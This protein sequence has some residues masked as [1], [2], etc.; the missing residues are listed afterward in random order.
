[1]AMKAGQMMNGIVV[2]LVSAAAFAGS[3]FAF[4][5][6]DYL[7]EEGWE[8]G[9]LVFDEQVE[10][11]E[12]ASV[13]LNGRDSLVLMPETVAE[14]SWDEE[15]GH[16][17]VDLESGGVIFAAT[18]GDMTVSVNTDFARVD[19]QN[20]TAYVELSDGQ[21]N[22]YATEH[23]SLVTFV[24]DGEDL[25]SISVPTEYWMKVP[26]SKISETV[27]KLRL[28]KL[29]KEFPTY[30][31][32][33]EDLSDEVESALDD[34]G[35]AYTESATKFQSAIKRAGEYGPPLTGFAGEA[36]E[37]FEQF[38]EYVTFM[39]H[40]VERLGDNS[41]EEVLAYVMTNLLYGDEETGQLWF[42]E[43]QTLEY[44]VSEV[45][46]TYAAL[47]FVLPDDVLYSVK[48][49]LA[50][51]I[52]A[53]EGAMTSLRLRYLEIESLL[54][55]SAKIEAEEA[56]EEYKI[57]FQSALKS[58]VFDDEEWLDDIN[59]EYVLLELILRSYS[60]FYTVDA[61]EL[62][63]DLEEKILALAGSDQDLD[64][65]RQA[66]VQSKLRFLENLF[67]FVVERKISVEDATELA[68]ELI[69]GAEAYLNSISS[70]SAVQ[71]YFEAKLDDYDLAVQFVNSPEF[72]SYT[73][74]DE[75][76]EAYAQK[77]EDLDELNEYIQNLRS[78]DT[79]EVATI[80]IEEAFEQVV[81][82][83]FLAGVTYSDIVWLED[84]ANRLFEIEG[85]YVAG[86]ALEANYDRETQ[87]F[88]DVVVEDTRF[89]TGLL[90]SD[91]RDVVESAMEDEL[92]EV[93]GEEDAE[94]E[95][96]EDESS[97]VEDVAISEAEGAFEDAGLETADFEI[98]LV[99]LDANLFSFEGVITEYELPV[100]GTFDLI[101][102]QVSEIVWGD[103]QS[104]PDVDLA[105]LE[106]AID[107]TYEA[108]L[109]N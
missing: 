72:Y 57:E 50:D 106:L 87:I 7:V 4:A 28:T 109:A 41:K 33:D 34:I 99:D 71:E 2:M 51:I 77:E 48:S 22:V 10:V 80:S 85:G 108:Q 35:F 21:M 93:L 61:I 14:L 88:Y 92:P 74:F 5:E 64:E 17:D 73:D 81:D 101:S 100:S 103:G 75:G 27:G 23:P 53:D 86:F 24:L 45:E 31:L 96:E 83:F 66:F 107:V 52:Y 84:S 55:A 3:F 26:E 40:A 65:E 49:A 38:R 60:T 69:F 76:L 25:N 20:S 47:F 59:R 30:E 36:N 63:S 91:L 62:L 79:D 9:E 1:M 58:G 68:D 6:A 78:G 37:V 98:V 29:S 8:M 32:D 102:G 42:D 13:Q 44:E 70:E 56:Y 104:L 39:P 15:A 16:L 97:L 82:D 11:S 43:W 18:A 105:Q 46:S 19:S 95:D 89:S 67:E 90:H 94:E 54:S 12:V